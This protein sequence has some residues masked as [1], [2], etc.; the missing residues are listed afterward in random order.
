MMPV[1]PSLL[2]RPLRMDERPAIAAALNAALSEIAFCT[3][4]N[5][6]TIQEQLYAANP[7]SLHPVQW[8]SLERLAA[9][10]ARKLEGFIDAG[11]GLDAESLDQPDYEPLGLLRFLLLVEPSERRAEVA[12]SLLETAEA[13][14]R[15]HGVGRVKAFHYSTGYPNFQAGLGALPGDWSDEI[16][17]LT[18]A[19]YQFTDRFYCLSRPLA[20]PVE[21][22]APA[23]E[24]SLVYGG[25]ASDRSYQLYR[26]TD[27]VG[28]AR[29]VAIPLEGALGGHRL[30][31]LLHIEVDPA[32][33][34]RNIGKWLVKRIIND[35]TLQGYSQ[36]V[37]HLAHDRH[38]A[39]TLFSQLGFLEENYRGYTLEKTLT[40]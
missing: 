32:W 38:I 21:E 36:L 37:A 20:D 4:F 17:A 19:G 3:P 6:A 40:A 8:Q 33:R 23:A 15:R 14:W 12:A 26:R 18:G 29:V 34:G 25:T 22:T 16:W 31:K 9:W 5:Q 11:V 24:L 35:Y 28:M 1:A 7:P 39:V 13:F 10:R 27:W 30:A 2:V